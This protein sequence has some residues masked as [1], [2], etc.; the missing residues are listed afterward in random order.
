MI[1]VF[2]A[3]CL[4]WLSASPGTHSRFKLKKKLTFSRKWSQPNVTD[5]YTE[6]SMSWTLTVEGCDSTTVK[7]REPKFFF[8]GSTPRRSLNALP[9]IKMNG[10]TR[11]SAAPSDGRRGLCESRPRQFGLL[12]CMV[13]WKKGEH[14]RH[15]AN[16]IGPG[17][18]PVSIAF[19]IVVNSHTSV[20][21][22]C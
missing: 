20:H 3:C 11:V 2:S 18:P 8:F 19:S 12:S 4:P 15:P 16:D 5:F 6:H 14:H 22:H 1:K 9:P 17:E 7:E 10:K 21:C 13:T